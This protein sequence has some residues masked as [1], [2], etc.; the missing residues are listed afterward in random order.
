MPVTPRPPFRSL[1][2]W[3]PAASDLMGAMARRRAKRQGQVNVG[4]MVG[5]GGAVF[6]REFAR[7]AVPGLVLT[8][9]AVHF[10]DEGRSYTTILRGDGSALAAL[11]LILVSILIQIWANY[12]ALRRLGLAPRPAPRALPAMCF[13][14]GLLRLPYYLALLL[15]GTA[16]VGVSVFSC[17]GAPLILALTSRAAFV[18]GAA[19]LRQEHPVADGLAEA[20]RCW[21]SL[22]ALMIHDLALRALLLMGLCMAMFGMHGGGSWVPGVMMVLHGLI[23]MLTACQIAAGQ[24]RLRYGESDSIV[25]LF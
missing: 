8:S 12:W 6:V 19:L 25:D 21:S 3:L 24:A 2:L 17:L 13:G 1:D 18:P 23:D 7:I 15:G 10:L 5:R 20:T 4:Q 16:A 22:W 11:V 14:F 9:L